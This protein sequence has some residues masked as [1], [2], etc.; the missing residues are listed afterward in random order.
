MSQKWMSKRFFLFFMGW[1]I[2]LPYWTGYLV[3][4]KGLSIEEA[5]VMMSFGLLMRGFSTVTLYPYMKK[6]K[7]MC[8]FYSG[9][10][11]FLFY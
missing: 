9:R 4:G 5:S 10:V 11:R 6:I 3:D 7:V 1:G 2:F 8:T